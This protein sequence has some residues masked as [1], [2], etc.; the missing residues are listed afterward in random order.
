MESPLTFGEWLR[1][2]RDELRFTR[3]EFAERVGCSV[4][5]LRKFEGDERRPS[6]QIAELI[7]NCLEIPLAERE[8]FIKVAR[9]ELTIDRLPPGSKRVT[10][11]DISPAQTASAPRVKL[12]VLPTPLI[13][14]Q[15]EVDELTRLLRDP[16]CRLLTLAG[17]GG[18]GKTRLAIETASQTQDAF[19]DGVYFVPLAPVNSARF[20]LPVIADSIGFAFRGEDSADPKLQLFNYLN[21]KQILLLADNL[22]HLL[23][24]STATDLLAELLGRTTQVK[25]LVTSRESLNLQGEW[26]F[27]VQGLPIP[28]SGDSEGTSVEL[29]LQRARRAHVGFNATTDDY[30]AIVRICQLVDGMPLGIELASA[31]VRTLS[32]DEIA[33]EIERG[34]DFLSLSA[35]DLPA[36]HRSMHAVFDHSWKLLTEEEQKVL[37]RL[38]VF[39]G[40]FQREAAERIAEA[41]L[42][43]LS[44]LVTKSLI[45]RSGTGRYDLHELIRQF[46]FEQLAN[47]RRE[48]TQTKARHGAYYMAL[49]S[50]QDERLRSSVQQEAL[51]ELTIE[52]E[53]IRSAQEWALAHNEFALIEGA[54]RAYMVFYDTLGWAQEVLDYLGR[55]R[56]AL[57][58]VGQKSPLS[59]A[60]QTALAHILTARALFAF[61]A[62]QHEQARA[63]LDRSLEILRPLNEPRILVETLTFLGIITAIMGNLAGAS[64]LFEEG[65]LTAKSIGDQWFAA[66][67]FTEQVDINVMLGRSED[68]LEQFQAAVEAWRKTGDLRFT[69]FGLNF[70][71]RSAIAVGRYAEARAALEES[72]A[73]NTSVG[74]RWGLGNA[75]QVLARVAQ[76]QGE[77]AQAVVSFHKSI[78]TFT[79][80]GAR[81][82]VA[83]V[84]SDMGRSVFALG[85]DTEAERIWR[86]AM[87]IG[88]ETQGSLRASESMVGL[89]GLQAKRGNIPFAFELLL[90][91]L[92]H[93][94]TIQE[95]RV[96]ATKLAAELEMKLTPEE[97]ESAQT[98]AGN[99]SFESVVEALLKQTGGV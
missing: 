77:H 86:E 51:A 10:H 78:D 41:S 67:C 70:L 9:D 69:A 36:R 90:L 72:I 75:Y 93:P 52:I 17:P 44:A 19:A 66:L 82:S 31:W 85:D 21:E 32:C 37:L 81:W 34:L 22:E 61:R 5:A 33:R 8:T 48:Q 55:V 84:L 6:H 42:S 20:I 39:R 97:I 60:E 79:E 87:R 63:M 28:E 16:H 58:T 24:D 1:Q 62:A 89:A 99:H 73:I 49:L 88:V 80:L 56:E 95:T 74:D 29:F 83:G 68:A 3:E 26:V 92:S 25:L 98:F 40:G 43:T 59:R 76:A 27:E 38:S 45:R 46:A 53:N 12:P 47:R 35:K 4:S 7:A 14:R 65:W 50:N 23:G 2:R 57:E 13:G 91:I 96:R 71:S 11:P 18:I 54:M 94:A 15:R 64:A 30:P